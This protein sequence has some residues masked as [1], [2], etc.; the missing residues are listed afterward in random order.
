MLIPMK[1]W[2][3]N[4]AHSASYKRQANLHQWTSRIGKYIA[5]FMIATHVFTLK[6]N[7]KQGKERVTM[8]QDLITIVTKNHIIRNSFEGGLA[9]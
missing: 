5:Y 2:R 6:P 9:F 8:A 1:K 3:S 4:G 7:P